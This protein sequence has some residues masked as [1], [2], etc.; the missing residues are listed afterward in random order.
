MLTLQ[1]ASPPEKKKKAIKAKEQTMDEGVETEE[2]R[3][4]RD[5]P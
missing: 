4:D 5:T 3:E 2:R 1:H